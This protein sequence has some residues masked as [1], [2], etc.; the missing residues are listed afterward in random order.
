MGMTAAPIPPAPVPA[1][2][3]PAAPQAIRD[4]LIDSEQTEF[5]Q[6]YRDA[7]AEA[8]QTLDLTQV[9]RVLDAYAEIARKTQEHGIEVHRRMLDR[10]AALQRGEDVSS[11]PAEDVKALLA[12]RLAQ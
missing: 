12:R 2:L 11:V 1:L 9:L 8:A 4:A 6:A 3:A 7:M 5:E 10:V